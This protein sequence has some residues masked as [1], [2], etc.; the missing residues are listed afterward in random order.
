MWLRSTTQVALATNWNNTNKLEDIVQNLEQA[1]AGVPRP[2]LYV[3]G[4]NIDCPASPHNRS[5]RMKTQ[6]LLTPEMA[7]DIKASSAT[8]L[9]A[10]HRRPRKPVRLCCMF[11]GGST[12]TNLQ[13]TS[14]KAHVGMAMLGVG[15]AA[16]KERRRV[17]R[18]SEEESRALVDYVGRVRRRTCAHFVVHRTTLSSTDWQG[19]MERNSGGRAEGR[20]VRQPVTSRSQGQVAVRRDRIAAHIL[21]VHTHTHTHRNL[22]KTRAT[23]PEHH[24]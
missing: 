14:R 11:Q 6:D 17:G 24:M 19:S 18:W 7:A 1:S 15:G 5:P 20:L 9:N 2:L 23:H 8:I 13:G 4:G 10:E 12:T 3:V 16:K 22:E 21:L